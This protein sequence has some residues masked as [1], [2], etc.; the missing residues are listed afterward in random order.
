MQLFQV[1]RSHMH[2]LRRTG[3]QE[4]RFFDRHVASFFC[5][6]FCLVSKITNL[7][8]FWNHVQLYLPCFYMGGKGWAWNSSWLDCLCSSTKKHS[9]ALNLEKVCERFLTHTQEHSGNLPPNSRHKPDILIDTAGIILSNTNNTHGPCGGTVPRLGYWEGHPPPLALRGRKRERL[10]GCSHVYVWEISNDERMAFQ[11]WA[12]GAPLF[13][14]PPFD[15][16][17]AYPPF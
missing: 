13:S 11:V 4:S 15:R 6:F 12:R 10:C 5:L 1:T 3:S 9:H 17:H 14:A 8:F 2:L 16:I 7:I